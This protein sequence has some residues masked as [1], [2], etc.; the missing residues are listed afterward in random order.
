MLWNLKRKETWNLN[1]YFPRDNRARCYGARVRCYEAR[2]RCY[3]AG[4]AMRI[5]HWGKLEDQDPKHLTTVPLLS[6]W[7]CRSTA[8]PCS[9]SRWSCWAWAW[10]V[11]RRTPQRSPRRARIQRPARKQRYG[12]LNF[13]FCNFNAGAARHRVCIQNINPSFADPACLSRIRIF[14]NPGYEFFH[15]GSRVRIK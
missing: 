4:S 8:R 13:L 11:R 5:P 6:G 3:G 14:L 10:W 15:P 2:A 1:F 7:R 9:K 12:N